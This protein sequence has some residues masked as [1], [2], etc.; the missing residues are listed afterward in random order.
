MINI[1]RITLILGITFQNHYF[2]FEKKNELVTITEIQAVMKSHKI[3]LNSFFFF[4]L[5]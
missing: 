1:I 3:F 2:I 4:L 5:L